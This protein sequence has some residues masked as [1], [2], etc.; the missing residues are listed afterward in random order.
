MELDPSYHSATGHQILGELY[1]LTPPPPLAYGNRQKAL[2]HL[3]QAK[4]LAPDCPVAKTHLAEL[5]ISQ[6]KKDLAREEIRLILNQEIVERGPFY[7]AKMKARARDLE[8]KL[9]IGDNQMTISAV[10]SPQPGVCN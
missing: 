7:A 6:R 5:Y 3:L 4:E 10:A 1:R 2:E 9:K 8:K